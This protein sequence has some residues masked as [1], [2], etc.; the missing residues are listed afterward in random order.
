MD[1][2]RFGDPLQTACCSTFRIGQQDGKS[3][4][5]RYQIPP[6]VHG[7]SPDTA[8]MGIDNALDDSKTQTGA[9]NFSGITIFHPVETGE[10]EIEKR[11]N[12]GHFPDLQF[13]RP[14]SSIYKFTPKINSSSLP[15][16]MFTTNRRSCSSYKKRVEG[17]HIRPSTPRDISEQRILRCRSSR[18]ILSGRN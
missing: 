13:A 4:S 7:Q 16:R 1:K 3:S 5:F 15:A 10:G 14:T 17:R 2:G 9:M 12:L 8:V 11:G 6:P 18:N